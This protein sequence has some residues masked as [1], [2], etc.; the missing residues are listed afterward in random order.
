MKRIAALLAAIAALSGCDPTYQT[1]S[2]NQA[3][4]TG[5]AAGAA[6][7]AAVNDDDRLEGAVVGGALGAVAGTLIGQASTPGNCVYR[8]AYGN[9]F[10]APC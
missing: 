3:A 6:L 8:D 4:L 10:V 5:A 7:G 9:R 2:T 1:S